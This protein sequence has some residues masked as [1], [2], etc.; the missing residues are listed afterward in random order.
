MK[1]RECMSVRKRLC[2]CVE[3]YS[4]HSSVYVCVWERDY[5]EEKRLLGERTR[6]SVWCFCQHLSATPADRECAQACVCSAV[7]ENK[8]IRLKLTTAP[9]RVTVHVFKRQTQLKNKQTKN[10]P[11][12]AGSA[13]KVTL[14]CDFLSLHLSGF[15]VQILNPSQN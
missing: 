15:S 3:D 10:I 1:K 7:G 6:A 12:R 9:C 5:R 14:N 2:L 8:R 4:T 11:R 13:W